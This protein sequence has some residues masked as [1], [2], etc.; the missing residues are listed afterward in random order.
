MPSNRNVLNYPV[1]LKKNFK[2]SITAYVHLQLLIVIKSD[3]SG[4]QSERC[5]TITV[6]NLRPSEVMFLYSKFNYYLH[7][8]PFATHKEKEIFLTL[9]WFVMMVRRGRKS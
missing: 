5:G 9:S 8:K 4:K 6:A 1:N 3:R 7:I 2:I